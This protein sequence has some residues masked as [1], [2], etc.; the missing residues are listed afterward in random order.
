[1]YLVFDT[2]TTG[3]PDRFNAPW[4]DT[5][6]WP[7]LV[8]LAWV[9]YDKDG[10]ETFRYNQIIQPDG[11]TIPQNSIN[12]HGI[13]NE[14]AAEEGI[15]M[16]DA[17]SEF[18]KALERTDYIIAHN[19]DFDL[20]IMGC[21]FYRMSM[22]NNLDKI[23]PIDT[24]KQ[25]TKFCKIPG[26]RGSYKYPTLTELHKK[27]FNQGF[28]NA[29]DALADVEACARCFFKLQEIG[30]FSFKES[31]GKISQ[32][33][34]VDQ[35]DI[36]ISA[37]EEASPVVHF[38]CHTHY[39]LLRGAGSI[40]NYLKR[41]KELG[42]PAIAVVDRETMSGTFELWKK[43]KEYGIKG[44][45]GAE[46]Y[47]NDTIGSE[48]FER[49]GY[50][51]KLIIKNKQGYVNLNKLM[52]KGH[53]EGFD[54]MYSRITT[55]WI[56][57]NKEGLIVTTGNYEGYLAH[58]YFRGQNKKAVEYWK[59]LQDA[60]GD[61]FIAEIKFSELREQKQFNTFVLK[62]A[63]KTGTTVIVD[64]DVHYVKKEDV[65][66][67][68]VVL[69]IKD[70][71][72]M[73]EVRVFERRHLY[74]LSRKDYYWLNQKMGYNY[75]QD[76]LKLFMDNTI[77]LAERCNFDF[78]VGVEK[79]PKYEPTD[80]VIQWAQST[81]TKEIITKLAF[82]KLKKKLKRKF[83]KGQLAQ[84]KEVADKYVNRLNY[85]LKVIEDKKMLD[86]FLV[87]WEILNDYRSHGKE[88][89]SAR[90]SA[91]GSL[92]SWCLDITKIDPL[93]F[94]LYFERF[95]NPARNC[96][97]EDNVVLMKDGSLK[98]IGEVKVGDQVETESGQ[99]EL[100]QV[101]KRNLTEDDEVFEIEIEDGTSI[102]LTGNH[103]VPV[104]RDG[105]RIDVMV[106]EI[107]ETDQIITF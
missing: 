33:Q 81:D 12:V 86:Y 28:D 21:E 32:G 46:L 90:G 92:L 57:E 85:E 6:N 4:T 54:K 20:A 36:N 37:E 13:T 24:S 99:G 19:I 18:K 1:M 76:V 103:V 10:K 106:D 50:P 82:A 26:R 72:K 95:L 2:E 91:A 29:H 22:D 105:K 40:D 35:S 70:G 52:Y 69:A 38:S 65:E 62:M 100:V 49:G 96:L 87:N 9:E 59:R 83:E 73:E 27:L 55:D 101:H 68:D 93:Q 23:F 66:L 39:S 58:L 51:V 64:N 79:Y 53:T 17:L 15:P 8:Q 71:R 25:T 3:L 56:L 60:F 7:R 97:T 94:D 41:A 5:D 102:R 104:I 84:T 14:K 75:P 31:P 11:Y 42:H 88:T 67:Q 74:Y 48:D 34:D 43:A 78:E 98:P 77:K 63:A 45:F 61:D 44:I 30:Y 80:N 107:T 16:Q 89:G 47:L